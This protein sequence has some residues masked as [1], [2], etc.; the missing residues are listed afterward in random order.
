MVGLLQGSAVSHQV[1]YHLPVKERLP[2]KEIHF[3]IHPVSRV[4]HQKVQGFLAHIQTHQRSLS[5]I[6]AFPRK[7]IF[8]G[9]VTIMG[10]MQ[11]KRLHHRLSVLKTVKI[12]FINIFGEK[13]PFFFQRKN[14]FHGLLHLRLLQGKLPGHRFH[15]LFFLFHLLRKQFLHNR[16]H[17]ICQ[18]IHYMNTA[19]VDIQYYVISIIYILM[20]HLFSP[21]CSVPGFTAPVSLRYRN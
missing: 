8:A 21:I 10:N 7:T 16:N 5:V 6:L 3:Q 11:T 19:A 15:N 18:F 17:I 9:Q 13:H 14:L 2:A 4:L 20:Y 1:F 12:L